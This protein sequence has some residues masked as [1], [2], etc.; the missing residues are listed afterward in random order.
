MQVMAVRQAALVLLSSLATLPAHKAYPSA[1][2]VLAATLPLLDDHKRL[3]RAAAVAC[4]NAWF[5]L[6]ASS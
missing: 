5:L 4:R 2:A 1:P 6:R 3:V